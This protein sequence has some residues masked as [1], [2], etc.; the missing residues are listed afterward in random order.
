MQVLMDQLAHSPHRD[1]VVDV[2]STR[3]LSEVDAHDLSA[4]GVHKRSTAVARRDRRRGLDANV[5]VDFLIANL[6]DYTI[7]LAIRSGSKVSERHIYIYIYIYI[8]LFI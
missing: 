3:G 4:S 7:K 1:D 8:Y 2:L 6:L 5:V